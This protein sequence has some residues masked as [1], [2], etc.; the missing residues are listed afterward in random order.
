MAHSIPDL[1]LAGLGPTALGSAFGPDPARSPRS[2]DPG[3]SFDHGP[4]LAILGSGHP[5][6]SSG[7][8]S[9]AR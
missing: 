8:S 7:S 9:L 2:F 1:G 5:R 4:A 6:N 3:P